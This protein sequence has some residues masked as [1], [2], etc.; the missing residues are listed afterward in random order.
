MGVIKICDALMGSGKTESCIRYMNEHPDQKFLYITQYL[1]EAERIVKSCPSL[2]FKMPS[3][4]ISS[5][6]FSKTK[7]CAY[8]LSAGENIA[9]THQLF[10]LY[11]DDMLE[12]ARDHH[13]TLMIDEVV[14]VFEDAEIKKSDVDVLLRGN[15]IEQTEYGYHIVDDHYEDGKLADIFTMLRHNQ[16]V[17]VKYKGKLSYYCWMMPKELLEAFDEVVV[18]TY[19]FDC[20]DFC[21][22]MQLNGIPYRYIGVTKNDA[23]E[24]RFTDDLTYRP[25][26]VKELKDK[27]HII[28]K[29]KINEIGNESRAL[30]SNWFKKNTDGQVKLKASLYNY[31]H[32]YCRD[33]DAGK[34]LWGTY[35]IGKNKISGK[36]YTSGYLVF[37][38][39]S[40][41]EFREKDHLAY[42]SNIFMQPDKR[43]WFSD[44]GVIVKEDRWAVSIM[45]QWIWRSAIRDGKEIWIYVPSR[46]MR[47]LLEN[48]IDEVS[49]GVVGGMDNATVSPNHTTKEIP[50]EKQVVNL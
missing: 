29:W 40:S 37:N 16:L 33:V 28:Y 42:C 13:Y 17:P 7:H 19:M 4:K 30:S 32:N 36:G 8:L 31:F 6:D 48:W 3:D 20:Q 47:T 45:T 26:Y 43:H 23:G 34:K 27:V 1:P 24:Y 12:S 49:S 21:Y 9:S 18:L 46:R 10:K 14:D 25:P 15:Y 44:N 38:Q 50:Y 35:K 22:Y 39:K 41:N 5:F 11:T 2:D